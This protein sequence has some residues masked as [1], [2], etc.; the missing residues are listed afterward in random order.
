MASGHVYRANRPNT[1]LMLQSEESSCQPG[2]LHT[3]PFASIGA[4]P[5]HVGSWGEPEVSQ[6]RADLHD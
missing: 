3:W 1:W 4:V 2:A 6:S 5:R